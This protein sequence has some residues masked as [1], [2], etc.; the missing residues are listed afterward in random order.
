MSQTHSLSLPLTEQ[1]VRAL[2]AGDMVYLDGEV[3]ITAGLP[4]HQRIERCIDAGETLP[5]DLAG[6]VFL[7]FGGYSH[8][9][10]GKLEVVYMN[11]TTSTRF[12]PYMP[13]IIRAFGLRAVGGKGG[14]DS[15][16]ARAMQEFGCVYLSFPGGACTLFS[17]AIREVVA[18]GWQDLLLHYRLLKLRVEGLGP[19]TVAIDA[20]GNS[21]Y[22][23]LQS[24][25]A[26]RLPQIMETLN[27]DRGKRGSE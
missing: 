6:A 20:H 5:I 2:R 12:N 19:G 27:A 16:S 18:V 4:T 8:E 23:E 24:E 21:L 10:N 11:P 14:L 17:R 7:H 22:D 1:S 15:A 9:V 3:V 26:R 25:A 13:K